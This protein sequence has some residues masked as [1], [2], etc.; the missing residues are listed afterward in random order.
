[1]AKD[2]T[3]KLERGST[4][5]LVVLYRDSDGNAVNLTGYT[6]K[7]QALQNLSD[8]TPA[9]S[10][11]EADG[12]TIT[13]ASGRLDVEI[14]AAITAALDAKRYAFYELQVTSPGSVVTRLL[15]GVVEV[16]PTAIVE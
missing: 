10:L 7:L 6:A 1:M 3:L 8:T 5:S 11:D 13:A 12:I 16:S 9:I 4:Y 14:S 2:F 15:Q